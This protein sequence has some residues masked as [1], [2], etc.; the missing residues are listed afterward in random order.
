MVN[1]EASLAGLPALIAERARVVASRPRAA[2][3]SFV[4]YWMHTALRVDENPALETAQFLAAQWNL[5][6]LVYQGLSERYP[7][8]CD[9]HHAFMLQGAWE[10][11]RE[12]AARGIASAFHLERPGHRGPFLR[13]LAER[14]AAVVTE[15]FPTAPISDWLPRVAARAAGPV[16]AID[17]A[18]V[19]PMRMAGKAFDRA[20]AYR[21]ATADLRAARVARPWPASSPTSAGSTAFAATAG[22]A[23]PLFPAGA[24]PFEPLDWRRLERDGGELARLIGECDIDH[25]VGPISDTPGGTQAGYARWNAFRR[26]GLARY[27]YDRNDPL[28]SGTSRLSAS[29][30]RPWWRPEVQRDLLPLRQEGTHDE[31]V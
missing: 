26:A 25:T 15:D 17:T 24:L 31:G 9:R 29:R 18:C 8:A 11:H 7:Y 27:A 10:T 22:L 5:P 16:F 12:L 13:L 23:T 4:L 2:D 6:L 14:A 1:V 3:G 20:F 19:V 21:D 28:R 30:R